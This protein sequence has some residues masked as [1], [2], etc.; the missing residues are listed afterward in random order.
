MPLVPSKITS[1]ASFSA[2]LCKPSRPPPYGALWR[3]FLGISIRREEN[4]SWICIRDRRCRLS[5]E[6]IKL[7]ETP[8]KWAFFVKSKDFCKKRLHHFRNEIVSS[9]RSL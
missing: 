1:E 5:F 4:G 2:F 6:Q 7:I 9:T 3:A 8:A